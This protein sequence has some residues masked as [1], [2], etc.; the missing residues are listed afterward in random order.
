MK[1]KMIAK[2]TA[3]WVLLFAKKLGYF[4]SHPGKKQAVLVTEEGGPHTADD[5]VD[6]HSD[7]DQ[8]TGCDRVHPREVGNGRGTTQNK[9]RRDDDVRGQSIQEAIR[10]KLSWKRLHFSKGTH[11]KKRKTR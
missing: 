3:V 8:E 6:G 10:W 1:T 5:D 9:H 7:W 2:S 11:P 4:G